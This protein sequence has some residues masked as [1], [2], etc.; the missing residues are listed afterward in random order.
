MQKLLAIEWLKLKNYRTFWILLGLYFVLLPLLNYEIANG[1]GS[2]T[3]NGV[4]LFN[5]SFAFP[6]VWGNVGYIGS[7]FIVFLSI[8]VIIITTNEYTFRTH[9]QNVIDGW[10][11]L[12]FLHAK[13]FLVIAFS[14]LATVYYFVLGSS[15]GLGYGGSVSDLFNNAEKILY[16]FLLSLNYLGFALFVALWIRRSG[17]AIS[18]YLLYS[19]IIEGILQKLLNWRIGGNIGD[20]LPLQ[21]SDEL[22]PLQFIKNMQS[23]FIGGHTTPPTY[24]IVATIA[25]CLVYYIVSRIMLLRRD[26]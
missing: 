23:A 5:R 18:L 10:K 4:N 9:R 26:W 16:F 2:F 13:V 11:R 6:D 22:L 19:V 25:W 7:Y 24:F 21:S 20:F 1:T 8:L 17:L 14:A 12:D 15:F 3:A